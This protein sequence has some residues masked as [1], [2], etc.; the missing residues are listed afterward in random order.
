ML[1][2][3]QEFAGSSN[4]GSGGVG[5]S[6]V[7]RVVAAGKRQQKETAFGKLKHTLS[8]HEAASNFGLLPMHS[9]ITQITNCMGS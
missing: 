4:S 1:L 5:G 8:Q 7:E 9:C 6:E 2:A 3:S